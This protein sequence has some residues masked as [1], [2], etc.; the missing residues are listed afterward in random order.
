MSQNTESKLPADYCWPHF[1]V[2]EGDYVQIEER[3]LWSAVVEKVVPHVQWCTASITVRF[4]GLIVP[5]WASVGIA[6]PYLPHFS[7]WDGLGPKD[8]VAVLRAPSISD[9]DRLKEAEWMA[10]VAAYKEQKMAEKA[11]STC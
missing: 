6:S 11:A 7:S 5:E 8:I 4:N 2:K 9:A 3:G 10:K 1:T